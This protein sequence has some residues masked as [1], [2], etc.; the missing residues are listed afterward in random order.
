MRIGLDTNVFISGLF[1]PSGPPRKILE[2]WLVG[3]VSVIASQE[4]IEEYRAVVGR[5]GRKRSVDVTKLSERLLMLVEYVMP[6]PLPQQVCDD[7]EDD[8]F[9]AAAIAG[10]AAYIVTGDKALLRVTPFA[11]LR[12]YLPT[13]SSSHCN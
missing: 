4:I 8:K 6:M 9:I 7:P 12:S 5:L 2:L 10:Q 1:W 3:K 11:K 13:R